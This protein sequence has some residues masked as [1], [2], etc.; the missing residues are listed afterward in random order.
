MREEMF[1]KDV[2]YFAPEL[3]LPIGAR[4]LT[5]GTKQPTIIGEWKARNI[6][7][8]LKFFGRP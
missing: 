4:H 5:H 7:A 8:V 3:K 6:A 1:R 2:P